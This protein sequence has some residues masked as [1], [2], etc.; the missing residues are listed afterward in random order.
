MCVDYV[1]TSN[2]PTYMYM[3]MYTYNMYSFTCACVNMYSEEC[4]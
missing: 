2:L 3:Y 4:Y 1:Y